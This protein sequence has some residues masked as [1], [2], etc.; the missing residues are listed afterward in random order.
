NPFLGA[1]G[2]G[3]DPVGPDTIGSGVAVPTP[4][5]DDTVG[6][7]NR[8]N[9]SACSAAIATAVAR[10]HRSL[11]V[12][13]R[14]ADAVRGAAGDG[15]RAETQRTAY[16]ADTESV[17]KAVGRGLSERGRIIRAAARSAA[18]RPKAVARSA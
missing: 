17:L 12:Y 10:L 1:G 4:C 3:G 8:R 16:G 13:L 2:A 14:D 11:A 5:H 15:N 6:E 7:R 9:V 18:A